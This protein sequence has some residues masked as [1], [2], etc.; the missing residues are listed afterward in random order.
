MSE[1]IKN[2]LK[3]HV[4][5]YQRK[6]FEENGEKKFSIDAS[7]DLP[8]RQT[9]EMTLDLNGGGP[10]LRQERVFSVPDI[11]ELLKI[12]D[13]EALLLIMIGGNIGSFSY[14]DA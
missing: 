1:G 3:K 4:V 7:F 12:S 13:T 11:M 9:F 10:I 6:E 14:Q 8:S 5:N 2:M